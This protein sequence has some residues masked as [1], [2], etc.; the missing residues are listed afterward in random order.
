MVE[1]KEGCATTEDH[2]TVSSISAQSFFRRYHH[3]AGLTGTAR[4]VRGEFESVFGLSVVSVPLHRPDLRT[5]LP[6]ELHGLMEEKLRVLIERVA[7]AHDSGRPVLIGTGSVAE[8]EQIST[9][10]ERS[11]LPNQ[12]LNA[13]QDGQEAEIVANAGTRGSIVVATNM[14]G[15]GTDIPLAPGIPD[16]GG[17][18]VIS[19]H[20]NDARRI[21]RQLSGRCARQG[22]PGSFETIIS[23]EDRLF[24]EVYPDAVR[25]MLTGWASADAPGWRL[26]APL[27]ARWAQWR[28][29]RRHQQMRL[30]VLRKHE[31]LKDLLA[32]SGTGG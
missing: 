25:T 27:V 14:A 1:I 10:L 32:F 31:D 5:V 22:D 4:E 20:L 8:S 9:V 21:D 26:A 12:V 11:G 28:K 18:H 2:E 19:T 16:I 13:S 3:L 24:C 29:E 30:A 6:L 23:L 7:T 15:R 17:L